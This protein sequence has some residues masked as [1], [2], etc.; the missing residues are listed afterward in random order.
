MSYL[1]S[2]ADV[3]VEFEGNE[4]PGVVEKVDGGW[5]RAV[6]EVD[7]EWDFGSLSARMSVHQTVAVRAGEVR[8]RE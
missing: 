1:V 3:W 2:G 8:A 7:P 6:I 5:V 4:W